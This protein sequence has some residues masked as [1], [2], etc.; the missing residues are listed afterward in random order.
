[1]VVMVIMGIIPCDV[2]DNRD[3]DDGVN[4]GCD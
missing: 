1:M 4:D 3:Y 2:G